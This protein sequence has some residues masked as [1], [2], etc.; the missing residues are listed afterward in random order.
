M[1]NFL[2]IIFILYNIIINKYIFILMQIYLCYSDKSNVPRYKII[3]YF[4]LKNLSIPPKKKSK[5]YKINTLKKP[6]QIQ[7]SKTK[8]Y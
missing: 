1:S 7:I 5:E 8:D 6:E 3:L 2:L 4:F